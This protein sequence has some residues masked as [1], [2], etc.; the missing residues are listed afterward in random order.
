LA[1]KEPA[2]IADAVA[3]SL[4][5]QKASPAQLQRLI[6]S[7]AALHK[8]SYIKSLK[9]TV[10]QVVLVDI[11]LIEA[12]AHFIV[13][14]DDRLTPPAMHQEMAAKDAGA[15][16]SVLPDAG[17]L[18][19]IENCPGL[20]CSS[21][22][23]AAAARSA[24]KLID[25]YLSRDIEL[26]RKSGRIE[27]GSVLVAR[28]IVLGSIFYGI[29]TMLT[30]PTR[31]NHAEHMLRCVLIGFGL[32]PKEAEAIAFMP[33]PTPGSVE[34]PIFSRLEPVKPA[35]RAAKRRAKTAAA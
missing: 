35:S 11:S 32:K 14:A 31:D 5:G 4:V 18:S 19:N 34:G 23:M 29:E 20:Q 30:E 28:D 16:V 15:P 13:G 27:V 24:R 21:A 2:D 26:A 1:G 17:H 8:D 9:A 6:D 25:L 3:R 33:L 10:S 12:P 7:I 22:R